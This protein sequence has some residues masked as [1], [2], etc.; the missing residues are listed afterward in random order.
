[1]F[2]GGS[3]MPSADHGETGFRSCLYEFMS[4]QGEW[5]IFKYPCRPVHYYYFGITY[6]L[7]EFYHC[8]NTYIVDR[9]FRLQ[10]TYFFFDA[11]II[12][13]Q[14]NIYRKTNILRET[15]EKPFC[16]VYLGQVTLLIDKTNI[17]I[18]DIYS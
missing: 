7:G 6:F 13:I 3:N 16:Y 18:A 10:V 12:L 9:Q 8:F 14:C 1:M 11:F 15:F 2:S 5:F 17:H 4:S